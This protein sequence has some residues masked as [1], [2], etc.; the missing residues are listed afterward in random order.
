V[1]KVYTF[2]THYKTSK[3]FELF[4]QYCTDGDWHK[5]VLDKSLMKIVNL[6]KSK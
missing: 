3:T 2:L 1:N 6:D 5:P 4:L